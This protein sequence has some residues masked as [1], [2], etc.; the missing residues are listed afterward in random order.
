[1]Q[2]HGCDAKVAGA[3]LTT[4]KHRQSIYMR[5]G[6]KNDVQLENIKVDTNSSI[7]RKWISSIPTY[8]LS[9][10]L[11]N[12]ILVRVCAAHRGR[13]SA[14]KFSKHGYDFKQIP[15]IQGGKFEENKK[16]SPSL[17]QKSI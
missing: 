7:S 9:L 11:V 5:I 1:M 13:F 8:N 15:K 4:P 2:N 16:D 12:I 17:R 14:L 10:G 3:Q 6:I